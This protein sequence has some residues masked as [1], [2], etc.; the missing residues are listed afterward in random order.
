MA[1]VAHATSPQRLASI[2]W[3][4]VCV[5]WGTTYLAIRIALETIPPTLLGGIRFVLAGLILCLAVLTTRNRFPPPREWWRQAVIGVLLLGVGN[6]FVV[7]AEQWVPSGIAAVGVAAL[8]FWMTG[9]DAAF[10]RKR[11]RNQTLIGLGVGFLGIV[12]LIWPSLSVSGVA[13]KRFA[14]GII[15][16]QLACMGWALGSAQSKRHPSSAGSVGASGLQQLFAGIVL[17]AAGSAGGEWNHLT[18]S[19]RTLLAEAYLV[20]FGSIAAYSAYLYALKHLPIAT[21]SLY[22]YINPVIAVMLGALVANEPVTPRIAAAAGFVLAGVAI[23]RAS[24]RGGS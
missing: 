9:A 6:G 2:A 15:F 1:V 8:P 11:V 17:L 10:S 23:V 18:V 22:A 16:L 13:S 24:T 19:T 4:T 12:L 3:V 20:V 7:W 5:V 21:V 14:L